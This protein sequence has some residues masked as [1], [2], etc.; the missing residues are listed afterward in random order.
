MIHGLLAL[1]NRS[2]QSDDRSL[3]AHL[4]RLSVVLFVY[5]ILWM[6]S[7]E[8]YNMDAPGHQ[9][10]VIVEMF[11][12]FMLIA[13]FWGFFCTAITEEK[14][15]Q[16]LGLLKMAGLNSLGLLLGKT[17]PRLLLCAI[18]LVA[19]LPFVMLAIA[20]GGVSLDQLLS[21]HVCLLAF[22]C[23]GA[24]VGVLSSVVA[25][26]SQHAM[27]LAGTAL[28]VFLVMPYTV[29]SAFDNAENG[30]WIDETSIVFTR[31]KTTFEFLQ[32]INPFERMLK[33]LTLGGST[34]LV[35]PQSVGNPVLGLACFLL[36]W[37]VFEP[38][39]RNEG[40]REG[41]GILAKA[42][43]QVGEI[44]GLRRGR[45]RRW[46]IFWKD[47]HFLA[48]GALATWGVPL[49]ALILGLLHVTPRFSGPTLVNVLC[50][51]YLGLMIHAVLVA[52][53]ACSSEVSAQTVA[54]LALLPRPW[55]GVLLE[56]YLAFL[57]AIGPSLLLLA[58]A[59][60][61]SVLEHYRDYGYDRLGWLYFF[62]DA[63]PTVNLFLY[64]HFVVLCSLY[65]RWGAIPIAFVTGTMA[66]MVLVLI[67]QVA[68]DH[69]RTLARS[70]RFA[71]VT[72]IP[73]MQIVIALRLR[74]LASHT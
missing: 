60:W 39:T 13:A 37:I 50:A 3:F 45:P 55:I 31:W 47:W 56:K 65:T 59:Y 11:N 49:L 25:R 41:R 72:L 44:R 42:L 15:E 43:R 73:T 51:A 22:L 70:L 1:S 46:A 5:W 67:T 53:R 69:E 32:S 24:G 54:C 33:I 14:E 6:V 52:G 58:V 18:L 21:A 62:I 35:T 4:F 9:L 61:L 63:M 71:V 68:G 17:V 38:C 7:V 23:L 16:T 12:F 20:L 66:F 40:R 64:I 26:T 74:H 10:I 19:E 57:F 34:K 2:L 29:N 30:G 28:F 48:G 36:A 27:V 8:Q